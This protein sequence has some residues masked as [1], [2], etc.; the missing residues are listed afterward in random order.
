MLN[1]AAQEASLAVINYL[2]FSKYVIL[3]DFVFLLDL[4]WWG[5]REVKAR[6][7]WLQSL[8][9]QS[10]C[11]VRTGQANAH[12]GGPSRSA[13]GGRGYRVYGRRRLQH[14]KYRRAAQSLLSHTQKKYTMQ[15]QWRIQDLIGGGIKLPLSLP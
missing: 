11:T 9:S 15:K 4:N 14:R 3:P 10:R 13:H 2:S 7:F 1:R 8:H 12:V 6:V 5:W